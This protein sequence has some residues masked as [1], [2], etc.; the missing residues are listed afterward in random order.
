MR[1]P[2]ITAAVLC[3]ALA[4][5]GCGEVRVPINATMPA[6]RID[7]AKQGV[8]RIAVGE[9]TASA[10]GRN[11]A[12]AATVIGDDLRAALVDLKRFEILDRTATNALLQEHKLNSSGLVNE[13][14]AATAGKFT[15]ATALV[16]GNVSS[17]SAVSQLR[18]QQF[19]GANGQS[20]TYYQ[21][22]TT[23]SLAASFKLIDV[24][25]GRIIAIA[26]CTVTYEDTDPKAR[27]G[28][29]S[30]FVS[31]PPA[32]PDVTSL[33][34]S[35]RQNAVSQFVN[36]IAPHQVIDNAVLENDSDI[37]TM[38][39]GIKAAQIGEWA[40]AETIFLNATKAKPTSAAAFHDLGIAQRAQGKFAEAT[41]SFKSAFRID[42]QSRY[43][44]E[45]EKTKQFAAG[46]QQK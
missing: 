12:D 8:K 46:D 45:I 15:G 24:E 20:E 40:E 39:S 44:A 43:Q 26:P 27:P 42:G 10:S 35:V 31:S 33:L 9:I 7:L 6:T 23:A 2:F 41:A 5:S 38:A 14:T 16:V 22:V 37:P 4:L 17:Y 18:T 19:K 30:S 25:T 34:A 36:Q 32:E 11:N 21:R 28:Q 3:G 13:T 29:T 1:N